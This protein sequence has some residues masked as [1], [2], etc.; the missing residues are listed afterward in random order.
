[1]DFNTKLSNVVNNCVD[2]GYEE[3]GRYMKDVVKDVVLEEV[4]AIKG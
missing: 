4:D 3:F 1:M 2:L